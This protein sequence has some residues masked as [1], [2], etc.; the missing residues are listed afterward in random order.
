MKI[1]HSADW[2][3]NLKNDKKIPKEWQLNRFKT[4]FDLFLELEEEVDIHIIAGDIFDK[5]P[6]LLESTLFESFANKVTKRTIIIPGNHEATKKGESFLDNYNINENSILN[7]NIEIYTKNT[8]IEHQGITFQLFPYT[9]MQKDNV[10][11]YKE[12]SILVTHIRGEIPPHITE[13][14]DFE[15]LRNWK[16]ILL[17]DIHTNMKYKDFPAYYPGSP[18][19]VTFDRTN[20]NNYGVN[21]VDFN[22]IDDYDINFIDLG[23][24]KLIRKRVSVQEKDEIVVDNHNHVIY[25]VTGDLHELQNI[26][27]EGFNLDKKIAEKPKENVTLDLSDADNDV[28]EELEIYL[29]YNNISNKE[30]ILND[31]K[32][33]NLH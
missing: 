24:P 11:N 2:H 13:E 6:N 14:F 15:K 10:P 32:D 16:L 31:F 20:K 7:D 8:D 18:M 30:G 1:L 17:G 5:A 29:K 28:V 9:D 25:E 22:G 27:T 19:N 26:D 33:L 21:I 23:L 3:I 12:D 4:M